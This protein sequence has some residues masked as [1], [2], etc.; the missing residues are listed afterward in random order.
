MRLPRPMPRLAARTG[1]HASKHA[2]RCINAGAQRPLFGRIGRGGS[3]ARVA[4]AGRAWLGYD[5][6]RAGG[7]VIPAADDQ[8]ALIGDQPGDQGIGL[9]L[10]HVQPHLR[11]DHVLD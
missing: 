11:P 8:Q 4:G 10:G 6:N 7:Q 3:A 1:H 9:Q 5:L 2:R